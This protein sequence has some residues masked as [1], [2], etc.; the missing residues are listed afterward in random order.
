MNSLQQ[1]KLK[2]SH[3]VGIVVTLILLGVG[4]WLSVAAWKKTWPFN[5]KDEDKTCTPDPDET[6]IGAVTYITNDDGDCIANTC[7]TTVGYDLMADGGVCMP[8]DD[9][10]QY[11]T[12]DDETACV[13]SSK[14]SRNSRCYLQWVHDNNY[15][16]DD[17][18]DNYQKLFCKSGKAT[19]CPAGTNKAVGDN[20]QT[21]HYYC[22]D[23]DV[24]TFCSS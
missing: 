24:D 8:N 12:V 14:T 17:D 11:K 9:N 16:V 20:K 21:A 15:T 13:H 1:P 2:K 19:L 18:D 10:T 7:N 6:V 23:L 5:K 3:I 22:G 4:I